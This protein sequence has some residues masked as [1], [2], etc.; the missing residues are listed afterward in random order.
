MKIGVIFAFHSNSKDEIDLVLKPWREFGQN[1]DNTIIKSVVSYT[2]QE[3]RE[4][5]SAK[6]N[7]DTIQYLKTLKDIDFLFSDEDELTGTFQEANVRDAALQFLKNNNVD[8]ICIWDG[9][10]YAT[11][12]QLNNIF[13]YVKKYED[14]CWYSI[15]YKNYVFNE[16][17]FL[18]DPFTPPR[19]FRTSFY[20]LKIN[21]FYLDNDISYNIEGQEGEYRFQ[22][23]P[24]KIIPK[25]VAWIKHYSWLSNERSRRKVIYQKK[26]FGKYGGECSYAWDE[27][28][29]KLIFDLDFHKKRGLMIPETAYEN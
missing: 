22:G 12:D 3:N 4:I 8:V 18:V 27:K 1:S 13:S 10:E 29:N 20:N 9:D 17:T 25:E 2:F 11:V 16:K 28:N 21:R 19:I 7:E 23:F 26:H 5:F 15:S 24:H 14:F 6:E